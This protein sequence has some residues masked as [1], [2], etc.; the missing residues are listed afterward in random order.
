MRTIT[1]LILALTFSF[2][3]LT[4]QDRYFTK[5][6]TIS[7]YSHAPLEDI[8]AENNQVTSILDIK[9]GDMVFAVLIRSFTFKKAL[10]QEHFNENY[11]DSDKYPK[12]KFKG[13]ILNISEVD[14][15]KPGTYKVK[16]KGTLTIRDKTRDIETE[17]ELKKPENDQIS[18]KAKFQIDI[19]DYGIKIPAVVKDKIA[20]SIEI[21]CNLLYGPYK[22]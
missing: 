20:K 17:A 21:S 19:D 1:S 2:G 8:R 7:F 6:G 5:S 9:T 10:M 14:L 4:A 15:T 13:K 16:I 18:G 3:I 12:A 22:K 11:M